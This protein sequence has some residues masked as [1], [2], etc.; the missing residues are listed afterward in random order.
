MKPHRTVKRSTHT[1][2][3]LLRVCPAL[4]IRILTVTRT[5]RKTALSRIRKA[6]NGG[7]AGRRLCFNLEDNQSVINF[8]SPRQCGRGN[9]A[10]GFS[11]W[12]STDFFKAIYSSL[13]TQG[14]NKMKDSVSRRATLQDSCSATAKERKPLVPRPCQDPSSCFCY[15]ACVKYLTD[16]H[17]NNHRTAGVSFFWLPHLLYKLCRY[18]LVRNWAVALCPI[19]AKFVSKMEFGGR[20]WRIC[21]RKAVRP[22]VAN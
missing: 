15:T 10:E 8:A 16:E 18:E 14:R 9:V 4:C 7:Y 22:F 17:A 3:P 2:G 13:G 6:E 21:G 5:V 11:Y 19:A 12:V 1:Q 20:E